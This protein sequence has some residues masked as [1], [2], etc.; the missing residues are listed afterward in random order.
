MKEPEVQETEPEGEEKEPEG[1]EKE[2]EG[3]EKEPDGEEK[4]PE[5]KEKEPAIPKAPI[6]TR[7]PMSQLPAHPNWFLC[8]TCFKGWHRIS[9]KQCMKCDERHGPLEQQPAGNRALHF[10]LAD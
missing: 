10:L 6:I 7:Y 4:E 9:Q 3:E 1:K 8:S 2:P 5:G